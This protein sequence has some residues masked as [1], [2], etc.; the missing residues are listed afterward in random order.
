MSNFMVTKS[1]MVKWTYEHLNMN[2]LK[3]RKMPV[4]CICLGASWC[5]V[6]GVVIGLYY[7][8]SFFSLHHKTL[9][10]TT[11]WPNWHST[12]HAMIRG[13]LVLDNLHGEVAPEANAT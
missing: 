8:Q 4:Q 13:T 12:L 2:K 9:Y 11:A 7:R 6:L 5:S 10:S 1:D 3:A